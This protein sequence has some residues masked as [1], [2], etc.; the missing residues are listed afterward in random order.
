MSD[1]TSLSAV[2]IISP[3]KGIVATRNV[4]TFHRTPHIH[5]ASI[6]KILGDTIY[7]RTSER[8]LFRRCR[9]LWG[10]NSPLKMNLEVKSRPDYFWFGTGMHYALEDYHGVNTYGHPSRAFL[11]YVKA[12][13]EIGEAP[14]TW[15][16]LSRLGYDM[17]AYYADYWLKARGRDPLATFVHNGIPQTEVRFEIELPIRGPQGQ[18]VVYR[19]MVD[20]MHEDEE[21]QLWVVEYK[22]AKA[23]RMQHFDT[24][25]QITAYCWAMQ[26]VYGRPIA[27]VIY[28]QHK[29]DIPH[30]PKILSTGKVSTNKQ[31]NTSYAL[32]RATLIEVYGSPS[33]FPGDNLRFLNSLVTQEEDDADPFIRRDKIYRNQHQIAAQGEK[34][35]LE[36]EDMLREQLPLYPN[37]SK[38]CTW[39]CPLESVCVAMDD[40][41][42]WEGLLNS[43]V[44][45]REEVSDKWRHHLPNPSELQTVKPLQELQGVDL[46]QS[47]KDMPEPQQEL[48]QLLELD[49]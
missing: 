9:R 31:M 25:D 41:S 46:E 33:S 38:D 1:E 43:M 13:Q 30:P 32:Y 14:D 40:G 29:K 26:A 45:N 35:L 18:R 27:G 49:W 34:I 37:P 15:M 22:S 39:L 47:I 7:I 28:Q 12:T 6:D 42:D 24:D 2:P 20:R 3:E 17:M 19:G 44:S 4:I 36:I 5:S 21:D 23:F 8:L 11:A 48:L 16:E 10:W